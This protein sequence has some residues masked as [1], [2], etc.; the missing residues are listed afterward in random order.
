V[1]TRSFEEIRQDLSGFT[2]A[3]AQTSRPLIFGLGKS[4]GNQLAS[5][6]KADQFQGVPSRHP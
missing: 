2:S 6:P 1:K 5:N 4:Y 3:D